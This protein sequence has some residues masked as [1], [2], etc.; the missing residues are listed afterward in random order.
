MSL[1]INS[2]V[3]SL[4]AQRNVNQSST[5]LATSIQR[6]SSGLRINSAK[7]DAAGLSIS[8]RFT[9]T[10]RGLEVAARNA[11]DGISLTQ[12]AESALG[13][14]GNNLQRVREL[15]VQASNATYSQTD[16]NALN[17][18]VKQLVGEID[19]VANQSNFNNIKL[20]DGSFKGATF[21]VGA[22]AGDVINLGAFVNAQSSNLGGAKFAAAQTSTAAIAAGAATA[23]GT[24]SGM[25]INGVSVDDVNVAIGDTGANVSGSIAAAINAKMDQTGVYASLDSTNKLTLTSVKADKDFS[26]AAGT[27][28]GATGLT[29]ASAGIGA[30]ALASA[31]TAKTLKDLDVSTTTGAQQAMSI[32][33]TALDSVTAS[34]ANMGAIQNR[35]ASTI[36]NI[37]STSENL[38]ASRSRIQDADYAKETA[39]LARNQI[40]QQA[41]V[42]MLAQANTS[43]SA[44]LRL[45]S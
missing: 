27:V 16:R 13:E 7:D 34:R 12:T 36:T 30:T 33:S 22:N 37:Q 28:T 32:V 41:G 20:L 8:E 44:V 43:G 14:I 29:V 21:Q 5:A 35:L 31:S 10:I 6:L 1:T 3:T 39:S 19:R 4:T 23:T 17:A 18:E 15:S 42:A 25:T 9:T 45:L 26:F 24:I 11:N 40:L 38:T 2:N